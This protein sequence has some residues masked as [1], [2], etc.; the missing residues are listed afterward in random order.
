MFS[1]SGEHFIIQP[2]GGV[3]RFWQAFAEES[4]ARSQEPALFETMALGE[5]INTRRTLNDG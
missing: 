4:G 1:G 5:C 2:G 3:S